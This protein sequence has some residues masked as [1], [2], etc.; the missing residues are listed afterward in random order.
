MRAVFMAS[1]VANVVFT[2]GSLA[3]L[4]DRVAIHF[5]A[6]GAADNWASKETHAALLIGTHIFLFVLLFLSGRLTL[7]LPARWVN[8]PNKQ[9]WL[10]EAN[11]ARALT[12]IE[13]RTLGMG[14]ALFAL[15]LGVGVLTVQANL[16]DPVRLDLRL[17]LPLMGLFLLY[18]VGWV[19]QFY[20]AFR[21]PVA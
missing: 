17:F 15:F 16:S 13:S 12:M 1:F 3:V 9:F 20:R 19:V 11:K 7:V 10:Q 5:G 18:T 21:V 6:L 4:P 14:T 2:L 8:L